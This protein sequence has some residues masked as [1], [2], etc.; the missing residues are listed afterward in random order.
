[1]SYFHNLLEEEK[2]R[3]KALQKG[4][5]SLNN[6]ELIALILQKGSKKR[7]VLALS[8]DLL[9]NYGYLYGLS[10]AP[11]EALCEEEGMG[12][13]KSC[14][15]L[16]AF[17]LAKRVQEETSSSSAFEKGKQLLGSLEEESLGVL[18]YDRKGKYLGGE[19]IAR[20]SYHAVSFE[21]SD[22]LRA[23]LRRKGQN[24]ILIHSHPS[25]ELSPSEQDLL[26]TRTIYEAGECCGLLMLDH[27]II[28]KDDAFSFRKNNLLLSF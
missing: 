2:P 13:S 10:H 25:G 4:L 6:A 22:I 3:E 26:T 11:L 19:V 21:A 14:A 27:L 8:R 9:R 15:L 5:I 1:M 28:S 23:I 17:E 12:I 24:Y 20:G 16:A 7:D 18:I